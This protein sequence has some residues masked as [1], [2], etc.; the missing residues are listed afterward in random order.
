MQCVAV[1][2]IFLCV[3]TAGNNVL[4]TIH[5]VGEMMTQMVL[6]RG[7]ML[8]HPSQPM[9]GHGK[10]THGLSDSEDVVVMDTKLRIIEILQV[11]IFFSYSP[12][13]GLLECKKN[14]NKVQ[15]RLFL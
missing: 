5:G 14:K 9:T 8:T 13:I 1:D 2:V 3:Y 15:T 4:R 12:N 11:C 7:S 10:K 6:S